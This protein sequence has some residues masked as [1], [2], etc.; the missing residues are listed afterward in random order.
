MSIK[1]MLALLL[2]AALAIGQVKT[3]EPTIVN[4]SE[5][6]HYEVVR[7]TRPVTVD[8]IITKGEW[9]KASVIT[10][11]SDVFQPERPMKYPTVAMMM[12]DDK[13][14]Y[15][16]YECWEDDIYATMAKHDDPVYTE[17][18]AEV[19]IDP[20]GQGRHYFE[21]DLSPRN[22]VIDLM[23]LS[24]S[25]LGQAAIQSHYDVIGMLHATKVR[26]TL[27]NR[28]DKDE[29]WTAELAIPWSNFMGRKVNVPPKDGDSWRLNIFRTAGPKPWP[30]ND[31]FLSWS[32]SPGVFH[33]PKNFG[34][35]TFRQ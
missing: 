23:I 25:F 11:F 4:P 14:L 10:R 5:W 35:V 20:E 33:Q 34:V 19:F 7:T 21:I 24:P 6:S 22:V 26:G 31:Q 17:Q 32:K 2:L 18:V 16:A 30:D 13:Y 9:G 8:G 28:N 3:V 29:K 1:L 15:I 12:W 27:D